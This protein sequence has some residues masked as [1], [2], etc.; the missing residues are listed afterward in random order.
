[1]TREELIDRIARAV[2]EREGFFVTEAQAKARGIQWP[3]RAQRNANPGNIRAW[4]DAQ[5]RPYPTAGGYVNFLAWA[6]ERFPGT[7]EEEVRRQ[8]LGEGWRVLHVLMGQYIDGKYT[9]GESLTFE[10]I[11]RA[12]APAEDHNDPSGYA[13]FVANRLGVRADQP[14]SEL[15]V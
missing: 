10:K 5:H 9:G 7:T 3:T 14:L 11:F 1:M 4:R 6:L 2:A 12:Y 8:A 15:L 13:R